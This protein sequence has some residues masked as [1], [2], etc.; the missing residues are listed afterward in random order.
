[1]R[2]IGTLNHKPIVEGDSNIV[3][4][5]SILYKASSGNLYKR[6]SKGELESI[7]QEESE[8]ETPFDSLVTLYHNRII[9]DVPAKFLFIAEV[10]D[11]YYISYAG[12]HGGGGNWETT[13]P[14]TTSTLGCL[15][16][17]VQIGSIEG[18]EEF[19]LSDVAQE[20]P[21]EKFLSF[22]TIIEPHV[23]SDIDSNYN[24]DEIPNAIVTD[25]A[26]AGD[27]I[28]NKLVTSDGSKM[29]FPKWVIEIN[30]S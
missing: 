28:K 5:N 13:I 16:L 15:V 11:K 18:I 27:I 6:N 10:G 7:S 24:S 9:I 26:E 23:V 17:D 19:E 20:I 2:R 1:M 12:Y 8:E 14:S 29:I 21:N 25:S 4:K 30:R 22:S 3:D